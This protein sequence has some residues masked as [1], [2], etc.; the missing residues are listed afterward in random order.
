MEEGLEL[1]KHSNYFF[2]GSFILII[3]AAIILIWPFFDSIIGAAVLSF[4]V[5]PVYKFIL[6]YL[7]NSILSSLITSLIVILLMLLPFVFFG[8]SLLNETTNFFYNVRDINFEGLRLDYI[9]SYFG[10]N[11][12]VSSFIKDGLNKISIVLIQGAYDFIVD[13]PG[14]LLSLFIIFFL[15]FYF[16]I[17]GEKLTNTIKEALP[18]KRRYKEDIAKKFR[19]S[20]YATLYGVVLTGIIQGIIGTIGLLIFKVDSPFLWG[21][22]MIILSMIPLV[23]AAFIWFPISLIKIASG[24]ITNGLGLLFYGLLI[25]STIDNII[26][27]KL[28]GSKAK[29][30]P[31]LALIGVFGGLKVFGLMGIFIGPLILSILTVFFEIYTSE[32]Y[33]A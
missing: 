27:P 15:M 20:I 3:I 1:K 17:D 6:K 9:N 28:I 23:G 5:Y 4:V 10:S 12:D 8:T 24:D 30:H 2:V 25:V 16:L 13:I 11:I 14:K 18:L 19:D 32:E 7:K 29:I 33:E 26:R 22:A 31:A 21:F